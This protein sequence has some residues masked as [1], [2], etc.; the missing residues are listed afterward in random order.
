MI[1]CAYSRL[2]QSE[3]LQMDELVVSLCRLYFYSA[4]FSDGMQTGYATISKT[5]LATAASSQKNSRLFDFSLELEKFQS[6]KEFEISMHSSVRQF[7]V[8]SLFWRQIVV[9]PN[10]IWV[11]FFYPLISIS[12]NLHLPAK[13]ISISGLHLWSWSHFSLEKAK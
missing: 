8:T 13:K 5:K 6:F 11:L 9:K 10:P 4:N 12:I 7:E 3:N 2:E 1:P